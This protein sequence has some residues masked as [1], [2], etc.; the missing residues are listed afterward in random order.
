MAERI[1]DERDD[2]DEAPAQPAPEVQER[3]LVVPG[4]GGVGEGGGENC[5]RPTARRDGLEG[6]Q[7]F[8][9]GM[10]AQ[11][12]EQQVAGKRDRAEPHEGP[13]PLPPLFHAPASVASRPAL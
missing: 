6:V 10:A 5:E 2:A 1:G 9:Q 4:E 12:L 13:Y 11:F 7:N 3:D 8:S